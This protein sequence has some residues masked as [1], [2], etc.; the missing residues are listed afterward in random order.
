MLS[1]SVRYWLP[2]VLSN[3][4]EMIWLPGVMLWETPETI[5]V[6]VS[7]AGVPT[8]KFLTT[9]QML[10]R[11]SVKAMFWFASDS[12]VSWVDRPV[13]RNTGFWYLPSR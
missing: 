8:T 5:S 10:V 1:L 11:S 13:K 7:V 2:S 4:Y 3:V 9:L 12:A 6:W